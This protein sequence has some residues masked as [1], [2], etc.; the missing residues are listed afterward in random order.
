MIEEDREMPNSFRLKESVLPQRNAG[1]R[2]HLLQQGKTIV[3][4][5]RRF[6]L[7]LFL[8]QS[9]RLVMSKIQNPT[10]SRSTKYEALKNFRK[11]RD[12]GIRI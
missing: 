6:D 3:E 1:T 5:L 10:G 12:D 7:L 9:S 2:L 8:M 11:K 4:K